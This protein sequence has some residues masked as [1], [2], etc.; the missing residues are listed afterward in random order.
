[1][2]NIAPSIRKS[3]QRACYI[4]NTFF[5]NREK[6]IFQHD[7]SKNIAI[8]AS[9][10]LLAQKLQIDTTYHNLDVHIQNDR[11][12]IESTVIEEII[13]SIQNPDKEYLEECTFS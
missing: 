8:S 2:K 3:L 5:T 7:D 4:L 9:L 10:F 13:R 11:R 1:M 12:F 6:A